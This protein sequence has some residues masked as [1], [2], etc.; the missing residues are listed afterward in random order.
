MVGP[1][2]LSPLEAWRKAFPGA[3]EPEKLSIV[4]WVLPLSSSIRK[5]N[6][7]TRVPSRRWAHGRLYVEAI[8]NE[9]WDDLVAA[10]SER[11]Y[12]CVAPARADYFGV[13]WDAPNGP[14]SRWSE[15]H[16]CYA[17]GLGTFGLNRALITS[18]GTAMRCG[19][20]VV[21]MALPPSERK[22]SR[23]ADCPYLETGGCGDCITRCPA[24]AITPEGKD[25]VM[26]YKYLFEEIGPI[27]N[28][29]VPVEAIEQT[30]STTL[31]R[32]GVC[33]LCMTAVPCEGRVPPPSMFRPG[34]A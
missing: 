21:D 11:G 26:C 3:A 33:G 19:S 16:Y 7:G 14:V 5:S 17:A 8:N 12:R 30:Q 31:G 32:L 27:V 4:G 34:A 6:R 18:K 24:G 1:S 10:L 22:G 9:V 13:D 20:V 29:L 25:N 28:E 15:R 23:T 2:H